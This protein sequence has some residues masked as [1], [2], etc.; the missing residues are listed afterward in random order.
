MERI[1]AAATP[2][3]ETLFVQAMESVT[4]AI[5]EQANA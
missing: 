2:D 1:L 4:A 5:A 3:I